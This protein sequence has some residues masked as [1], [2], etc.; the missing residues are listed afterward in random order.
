M[1]A[2]LLLKLLIGII[3]VLI[4]CIP[5]W[6]HTEGITVELSCF[7]PCSKDTPDLSTATSVSLICDFSKD[8]LETVMIENNTISSVTLSIHMN[9]SVLSICHS[10]RNTH[11]MFQEMKGQGNSTNVS[12]EIK[13][14][15]FVYS[16]VESHIKVVNSQED[17]YSS[18]PFSL[19][20]RIRNDT[21]LNSTVD[22]VNIQDMKLHHDL[23]KV[24]LQFESNI[25]YYTGTLG[26]LWLF[27]IPF[28]IV[29]GLI[30]VA[31]KVIKEKNAAPITSYNKERTL[32]TRSRRK[33][34]EI[35][36]R[37]HCLEQNH[38]ICEKNKQ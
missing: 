33:Q 18:V 28:V 19:E 8:V 29:C 6:F 20:I 15:Y 32:I 21:G 3:V 11:P 10:Q 4:V 5:E 27:L 37:T 30:F 7:D 2:S 38:P 22:L 26:I 16:E 24:S 36:P 14:K 31:C 35:S 17:K 1:A 25:P 13:G 9:H 34:N 23:V 12:L